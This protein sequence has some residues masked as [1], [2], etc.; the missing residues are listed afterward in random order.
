[1]QLVWENARGEEE[2]IEL[3]SK[4]ASG[5]WPHVELL[6][7]DLVEMLPMISNAAALSTVTKEYAHAMEGARRTLHEKSQVIRVLQ[8]KLQEH[9]A[10]LLSHESRGASSKLEAAGALG[11]TDDLK[12]RLHRAE[13][14]LVLRC[15][16]EPIVAAYNVS[17][18]P[19]NHRTRRNGKHDDAA[20]RR[21]QRKLHGDR[22]SCCKKSSCIRGHW[23][24]A[25]KETCWPCAAVEPTRRL[26]PPL[27]PPLT[28]LCSPM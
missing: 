13:V 25:S 15:M 2:K 26:R 19:A 12:A 17:T 28:T 24:G 16:R 7:R 23:C 1:M 9:A 27:C 10:E 5:L 8:M 14:M 20:L 18:P 22:K 4:L 3:F 6:V 21:R 11:A